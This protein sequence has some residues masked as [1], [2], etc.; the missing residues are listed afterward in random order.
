[1]L[2]VL[3]ASRN[4]LHCSSLK[5]VH[6]QNVCPFR[7]LLFLKIKLISRREKNSTK[8]RTTLLMNKLVRNYVQQNELPIHFCQLAIHWPMRLP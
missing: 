7:E 2:H 4:L 6:M 3:N 8:N 1:M 5:V